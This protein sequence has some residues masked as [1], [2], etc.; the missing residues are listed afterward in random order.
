[1]FGTPLELSKL[2]CNVIVKEFYHE[3]ELIF[4]SNIN[5]LNLPQDIIDLIIER[6]LLIRHM[7]AFSNIDY[8][9]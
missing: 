5:K 9:I 3:N 4:R 1:M 7:M 8:Y 2:W 6:Y